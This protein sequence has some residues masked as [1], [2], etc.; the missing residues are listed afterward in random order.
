MAKRHYDEESGFDMANRA[1][2]RINKLSKSALISEKLLG[3]NILMFV[4]LFALILS[5]FLK[6]PTDDIFSINYIVLLLICFIISLIVSLGYAPIID[7]ISNF[8]KNKIEPLRI[9]IMFLFADLPIVMAGIVYNVDLAIKLGI[10]ILFGQAIIVLFGSFIKLK[11]EPT[12]DTK[13]KSDEL[14][15]V[16]GK[17]DTIVGILGFFIT[18]AIL[19]S[20]S[21]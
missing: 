17:I 3:L 15:G 1:L 14:W 5:F 13:V 2:S 10:F 19:I 6:N 21:F 8:S 4:V 16:L 20:S 18:I 12:K 11:E 7:S 9:S